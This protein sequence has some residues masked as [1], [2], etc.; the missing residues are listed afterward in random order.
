MCGW[1]MMRV[2]CAGWSNQPNKEKVAVMVAGGQAERDQNSQKGRPLCLSGGQDSPS[3]NP[4][5]LQNKG[6]RVKHKQ[7]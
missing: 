1:V 2:M 6:S 5:R 7:E 4:L 3:S